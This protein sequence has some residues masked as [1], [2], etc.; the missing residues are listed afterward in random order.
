MHYHK[1]I[2]REVAIALNKQQDTFTNLTYIPRVAATTTTGA[3]PWRAAAAEVAGR[4]VGC[5][6]A[7]ATSTTTNKSVGVEGAT[8]KQVWE[9]Q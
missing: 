8:T 7:R 4:V 5:L 9:Q 6:T 1:E 2:I 3:W